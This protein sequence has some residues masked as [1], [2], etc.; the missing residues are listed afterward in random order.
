M[1][2]LFGSLPWVGG[3]RVRAVG[4]TSTGIMRR[5]PSLPA[6]LS[7]VQEGAADPEEPLSPSRPLHRRKSFSVHTEN[8][9][10]LRPG[11]LKCDSELILPDLCELSE[12][13]APGH[14]ERPWDG[15]SGRPEDDE[16][17]CFPPTRMPTLGRTSSTGSLR[18]GSGS[19]ELDWSLG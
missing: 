3:P 19:L 2:K 13:V 14:A 1:T 18:R 11:G 10:F 7:V 5:R 17:L 4:E 6:A 8:I 15:D 9:D 12:G 16:S